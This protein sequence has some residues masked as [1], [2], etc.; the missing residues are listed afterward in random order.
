MTLLTDRYVWVTH[1]TIVIQL[2]YLLRI[3]VAPLNVYFTHTLDPQDQSA[4]VLGCASRTVEAQP[5]IGPAFVGADS[6]FH[7]QTLGSYQNSLVVANVLQVIKGEIDG[8]PTL[9]RP[10]R[11]NTSYHKT[12]MYLIIE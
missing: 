2:I 1:C 10:F 7:V 6:S 5:L 3:I 12:C 8:I 4:T 11:R 9:R